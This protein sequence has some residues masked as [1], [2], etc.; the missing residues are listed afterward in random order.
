MTIIKFNPSYDEYV[1]G[2][3]RLETV[4]GRTLPAGKIIGESREICDRDDLSS[5]ITSGKF[6][7]VSLRRAIEQNC[8]YI[9]GSHWLPEQRFPLVVKWLDCSQRLSLQVHPDAECA[10]ITGGESKN[11][12]WYFLQTEP[13]S[14]YVAGLKIQMTRK[15]LLFEIKRSSLTGGLVFHNSAAGDFIIIR[16]GC[17][18]SIGAGNL[19]LEVQENSATTYR[20][21]DWN[22]LGLDGK[23]RELHIEKSL[24]CI[25]FG[26]PPPEPMRENFEE[27]RSLCSMNEFSMTRRTIGA[28]EKFSVRAGEQPRIITMLKGEMASGDDAIGTY[29]NVLLPCGEAYNFEPDDTAEF[30]VT[31]NFAKTKRRPQ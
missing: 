25:K 28:G 29:E 26:E 27:L 4:L 3:R 9:M 15:R 8:E 14:K 12:V 31:E 10:R 1:W 20:I 2:G 17:L 6:A 13:F 30:I 18:H 21:Y 7:G 24:E 11:E 23:P 16:G 5:T 22:R 19:V